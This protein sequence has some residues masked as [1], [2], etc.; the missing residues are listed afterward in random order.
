MIA[1]LRFIE[2]RLLNTN[3]LGIEHIQEEA[4]CKGIRWI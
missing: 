1:E 4:E 2:N 3:G